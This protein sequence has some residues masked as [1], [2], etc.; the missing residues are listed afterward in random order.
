MSSLNTTPLT[1]WHKANNATMTTLA[2]WEMPLHYEAGIAAEHLHTRSSAG[3]FDF[4]HMGK[5]LVHGRGA[6]STLSKVIASNIHTLKTGRCRYGFLLN[7]DGGVK[8]DLILYRLADER[9]MLVVNAHTVKD[10][11]LTLQ[12]S[13]DPAVNFEDISSSTAKIDL[14]G[15]LSFAVLESLLPNMWKR[16]PY[17]GLTTFEYE[18]CALIVSRTGYTGELGVEIYLPWDKAQSIW[19]LLKSDH[20]VK[21]V[22]L[23]A[24]D[25][26]RLEAG[27]PL[28]GQDLDQEH[29]PAEAG[30]TAVLTSE[31]NYIGKEHAHTVKEKLVA[32]VL[33]NQNVLAQG[34][35]VLLTSGEHVG[36]ITSCLFSPSLGQVIALA[37]VKAEFASQPEFR[38]EGAKAKLTS[39]PFYKKG[40]A[41][42][43]L[44]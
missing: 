1:L 12:E 6:A 19:N 39:L 36:R 17:F 2:G 35:A 11:F 40:T 30:F 13:L 5:F 31:A 41:R 8:D 14:Q 24:R 37:Y 42:T 3:L 16:L 22:G 27:L 23:G 44:L 43:A 38:V 7:R 25:T 9:F 4:S 34:T 33:D 32:L 21:P 15:P 20:R 10:D 29:S 26:L 28:Y 18:G